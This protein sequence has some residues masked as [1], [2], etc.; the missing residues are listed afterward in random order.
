MDDLT[1]SEKNCR[2]HLV[3]LL[4][5]PDDVVFFKLVIVLI[6]IGS[7]LHFLDG[8][9]FLMLLCLVK[10][11]VEL[12]EILSVIHDSANRWGC[13]GRYLYQVQAPLLS[14]PQRL[15]RR[16]DSELLVL[17][18]NDPN[19]SGPDSLVHPYVFIDGLDLLESSTRTNANHNKIA[20]LFSIGQGRKLV[21]N[22]LS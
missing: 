16:H 20:N 9:I 7:K 6:R 10:F 5:E 11:L 1:S 8:N 3:A 14:D 19:F 2:F 22:V 21:R 4:Q 12:V 17:V 15:L 18:A 13:S